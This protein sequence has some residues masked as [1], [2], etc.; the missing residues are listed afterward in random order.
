MP[1]ILRNIVAVIAG[2]FIGSAVNMAIITVGPMVIPPPEG[3]DMADM[4]KFA[5]NLKLLKPAN[6]VAPL[7]AHA[8]GTLVGAMVAAIIA[9]SHKRKFALGIGAFF[10]LGGIAMVTMFGGPV[11]FAVLDLVGAYIPMGYL[12]GLIAGSK[13]PQHE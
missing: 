10:L 11:W 1:A 7:L 8:L 9:A 13:Q 12:G 5:D 3:V 2:L 4:E 6:F